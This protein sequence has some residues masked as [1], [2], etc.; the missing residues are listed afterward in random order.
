MISIGEE[1]TIKKVY[2]KNDL[3]ILE[4]ANPKYESRFFTKEE[5]EEMP[6]QIMGL[7]RFVRKDFV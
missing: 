2:Y 6:V 1:A 3:M 4:A 7:V 5:V